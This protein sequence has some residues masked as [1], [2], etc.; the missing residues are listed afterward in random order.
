MLDT[1]EV[2]AEYSQL[3]LEMAG[4]IRKE[5]RMHAVGCEFLSNLKLT[6]IKPLNSRGKLLQLPLH[7]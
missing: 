2:S 5:N 7:R 3:K 4:V 1:T 6:V